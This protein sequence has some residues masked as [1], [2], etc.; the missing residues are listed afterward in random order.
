MAGSLF[1]FPTKKLIYGTILI[2]LSFAQLSLGQTAQIKGRVTDAETGE[3][4]PFCN[5]F[6][7]NTTI[8]T[9]TTMEGDY[10]L[11]GLEPGP[12]EV[13]FSFLGYVAQ[14][15][16]V[17][18]SP[19]GS[20]TI[21]MSLDPYVS[22]LSD[23]EIKA[24]RD[25]SWERDLRKFSN[26]FLGND[27]VA[28]LSEIENPWVIDF[29]DGEDRGTFMATAQQPIQITNRYLGYQI[30]FD[31]KE[32]FQSSTNYKIAG[33]ARFVEMTPDSE[34]QKSN[35]D[36]NRADV[37]R[38]SPMN[39]FRA[40]V[41]GEQ[42]QEGFFLYGDKP[43]GSASMNMRSDV[44]ANEL[45]KSV[46]P[47]KPEDLVKT[48]D[49]PGEYLIRMKGRIEIHYQK[50]YT[51]VNTYTDAPY[52]ISWLEVNKELVRVKENGFILNPQ[53]LIFAGDM[54][55]KRISTLLPLDYDA[56][57]AIQLQNLDKTA[58]NYQEKIYLHTDKPY[59]YAG[60]QI[61]FKGYLNYGNPYLRNELSKVLHL[62]LV[63][64]A[65][66]LIL[67]KNYKIQDGLV[68]GNLFL[69][70]SLSGEKY[71]LRAFTNWTRNYGP[72]HYFTKPLAILDPFQRIESSE[73]ELAN[74]GE[75]VTISTDKDHY[76][77]REKVTLS[78][79]VKTQ[80]GLPISSTL[81]VAVL[82][83]SQ[84]VPVPEATPITPSLALASIP[85]SMGLDRFAYPVE[86]S[87]QEDWLM[88]DQ[89]GKPTSGSVVVFVN[90]FE[91]MVNLEAN[92][93][94]KFSLEGME[95]YGKMN[96]DMQAS[97]SKGKP[98]SKIEK[99]NAL[100][101]PLALPKT[102]DFPKSKRVDQSI[103]PQAPLDEFTQLEEV[104]I[105][106]SIRQTKALYGTPSYVVTGAQLTA[107]GNT[108]DLV[109][110]LAGNVPGMRVTVEGS[111]GRQQIR[112]RSGATSISG[113]MEPVIMLNGN[114]MVS[115][116]NSTASDN[117]KSINPF[118]VDRVEIVSRTVSMLGN[119]GRNGV[120]AIYLKTYDPNAPTPI[121]GTNSGGYAKFEIEGFEPARSFFQLDYEQET[122]LD[123][124]DK[125]QTLYWNPFLVTDESGTLTLS[126]YTNQI[127][128]PMTVSIRGLG[129]DGLPISGTFT[130]NRK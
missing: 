21:N 79:Q 39:M 64:S 18:L 7:N 105:K 16:T 65:R 71:Y 60:E 34:T 86:V 121:Q 75:R 37:Y 67:D 72:D 111:S 93:E 113:S 56:E 31:L 42:E 124:E 103:R 38:K 10:L 22:E 66:N 108:S 116:P 122:N 104:V 107:T 40:I 117:I 41:N 11:E 127:A 76:S 24:S 27:A 33:A 87:L 78:I 2:L 58:E 35:W 62:E 15:K 57:K 59:Y 125:R 115:S 81:S 32:F 46:V 19:G 96:L 123:F 30:T 80:Q 23:V 25:K 88:Y 68:F 47:Y 29:E 8:S 120:I 9:A 1:S 44:F 84:V 63:D 91:G 26:Y 6:I 83:Q 130:I 112:I 97:D 90:D 82:D 5:V 53:D 14:T 89:K 118:D 126:F 45:G 4:L 98:V 95:F 28:A 77:P 94:G 106:D 102:V 74:S 92:R 3:T 12:I 43:G 55:Q 61:F 13:G 36:Q 52:P 54:D 114:V 99:V 73:A 49:K 129:L 110:S 70:D 51:Q 128:G 100:R 85:E 109:N 20:L 48:T 101:P 69:P 50:G 17:T 119:E